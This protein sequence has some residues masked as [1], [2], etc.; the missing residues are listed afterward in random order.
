MK[1][2]LIIGA[3]GQVGKHIVTKMKANGNFAPKALFRRENQKEF[4]ERQGINY[5]IVDLEED[6]AVLSKAMEGMD[7]IVFTAGS[8]GNTGY[9][10]TL[11]IDLD[12]AVKSM[13]AA[14]KA[15]VKRFIM[16]S[17]LHADDRDRWEESGIKPYYVAKYYADRLL[18]S[19][20]LDYTILRPGRLFNTAG[21]GKITI[22]DPSAQKGV[23]REDVA[24]LVLA[25]L[26]QPHTIGKTISFNEG[27][28]PIREAVDTI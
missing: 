18:K 20:G 14:H 24:E 16:V 17:A 10:K 9:D 23:P 5:S 3:T 21:S 11:L 25:V 26:N 12:G 27:N 19:S 22:T 7:A 15:G 4:F 2:V 6:I 28:T 1:H 13:E 8:G